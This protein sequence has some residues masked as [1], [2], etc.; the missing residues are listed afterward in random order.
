MAKGVMKVMI[1]IK[2]TWGKELKLCDS[3]DYSIGEL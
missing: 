2:H 3:E 1:Q